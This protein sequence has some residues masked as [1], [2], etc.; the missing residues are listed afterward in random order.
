M[1]PA[2]GLEVG[3]AGSENCVQSPQQ[4]DCCQ[5]WRPHICQSHPLEAFFHRIGATRE[6]QLHHFDASFID[7]FARDGRC[8]SAWTWMAPRA[9]MEPR[10]EARVAKTS[11]G[12]QVDGATDL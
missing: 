8:P 9:P 5:T 10:K 12:L 3:L 2:A 7:Y 11:F 1:L 6:K 4:A